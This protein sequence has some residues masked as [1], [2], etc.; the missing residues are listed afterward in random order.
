[1]IKFP[2][3]EVQLT[4][5]DG[6]AFSIMGQVT[7][8]MRRGGCTKQQCDEYMEQAMSGDYNNLLMVSMDTVSVS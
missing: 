8:A 3:I 6:N 5:N 1:M 7:K 4:G 2:H